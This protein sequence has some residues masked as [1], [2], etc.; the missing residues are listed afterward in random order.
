[1]TIK[2]QKIQLFFLK[3]LLKVLRKQKD[4]ELNALFKNLFSRK[5]LIDILEYLYL[6]GLDDYNIEKMSDTELLELIGNDISI[7]EFY[8]QQFEKCLTETPELSH[9][10]ISKFFERTN[11][12]NHY[13]YSKPIEQWDEYDRSNYYSLLFKTGTTKRVFAIFT[14]EVEE[15]D[16]YVVTTQPSFFFDTKEEATGELKRIINQE[17][18]KEEDLKIMALWKI[19]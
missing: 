2:E 6:D 3:Y 1:M 12:E 19:H 5:E 15:K 16:K 7:L 11:N 4:G 14:S 10:E 8:I 9:S 13:L 17:K 18:F